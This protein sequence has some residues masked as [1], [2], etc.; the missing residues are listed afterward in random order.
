MAAFK[1]HCA[2]G[3]WK[4]GLIL[5]QADDGKKEAMGQFGRF[6]SLADLPPRKVLIGYVRQAVKLNEEGIKARGAS[7][8]N[9][10]PRPG[11]RPPGF[12][13]SPRPSSGLP[14]ASRATGST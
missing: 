3:F 5:R 8:W 4:E 11:R 6:R 13:A 2:F 1:A 7:T 12:A 14:R 10:S 9:G